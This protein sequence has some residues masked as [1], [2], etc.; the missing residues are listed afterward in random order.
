MTRKVYVVTDLGSGDGGKGG[1]V[2]AVASSQRAHTVIK[3]GGAQGSHGVVSAATSQ[4]Y[5]FGQW[6][7]GTLDG[8]PTHLSSQMIV[9]PEGLLNE[10]AELYEMT[11][12]AN[13]FALLTV[14]ETALVATPLHGV[15]SHLFELSLGSDS[16]GTVGTG[17]GQSFR[18]AIKYPELALRVRDLLAP[19][20]RDRLY[21]VRD[22]IAE[23]VWPVL[24][25]AEFLRED[26]ADVRHE[27]ALLQ[28][29]GFVEHIARRFRQA[30]ALVTIVPHD[31][32]GDTILRKDG[33][34][35]IESSHGVL[36][37][38]VQGFAPHTSAIRTLPG[39]ARQLLD[40]AGYMGQIVNLGVTRAYAVRHGAGPLPTGNETLGR[41]LH[42]GSESQDNRYQGQVR[43]GA[44]D[45]VLLRYAVDVCGGSTAFDGLAVTWFDQIKRDGEWLLCDR[46]SGKLDPIA[47]TPQGELR[48]RQSPTEAEQM[49]LTTALGAV[50]PVVTAKVIDRTLSNDALYGICAEQVQSMTGVPVRMVS[51]G[52]SERDKLMK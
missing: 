41:R 12:I 17:V 18:D 35:V 48:V 7:C 52:P 30:G 31:Y 49:Q 39:Q 33:V 5:A 37:D 47:F 19:D 16:R 27:L 22:C 10:A 20:L 15:A 2:H 29:D 8:I 21:A 44:L 24:L 43:A 14:D 36:T 9:S 4:S 13:P 42:P 51:M 11:N 32:L 3:R 50:E 34:A 1:V 6:G 45:G 23:Y 46:Y 25:D 26:S 38:N 40:D 28:D